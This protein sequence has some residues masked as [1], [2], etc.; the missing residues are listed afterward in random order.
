MTIGPEISAM[1][2]PVQETSMVPLL[3]RTRR[4][5]RLVLLTLALVLGG[6]LG[7]MPA[8]AGPVEDAKAAGL[9]G[10]Q[11]DGYLGAVV[12]NPPANI[13]ALI[14]DINAKRMAAYADIAT[15][16]GTSV[17]AVGAVTAQKLYSEAKPGTFLLVNGSWV[18]K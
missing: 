6:T 8:F 10:E 3:I 11:P 14:R 13:A 15:K 1:R 16:N 4:A 2:T 7:G 17:E 9:I 12:G 18:K 5:L